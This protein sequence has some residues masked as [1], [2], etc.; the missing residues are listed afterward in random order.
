VSDGGVQAIEDIYKFRQ[1][2]AINLSDL[3]DL[4]E[5]AIRTKWE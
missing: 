5:S 2:Q 4:G 1:P 3:A